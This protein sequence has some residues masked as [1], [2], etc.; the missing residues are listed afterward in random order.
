MSAVAACAVVVCPKWNHSRSDPIRLQDR[1][2]AVQFQLMFHF[3]I[4][5]LLTNPLLGDKDKV[6][7][8]VNMTT[9]V[10]PH[11]GYSKLTTRGEG[12][13]LHSS[14]EITRQING[15]DPGSNDLLNYASDIEM[16]HNLSGLT[17]VSR[18]TYSDESVSNSES[19]H[20]SSYT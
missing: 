15:N 1:M 4:L 10:A 12:F 11:T 8:F 13:L 3:L 17:I 18:T 14:T 16:G 6:N 19:E 5:Y 9:D 20:S 2:V 7:D